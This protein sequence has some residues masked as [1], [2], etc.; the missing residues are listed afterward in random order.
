MNYSVFSVFGLNIPV[1]GLLEYAGVAIAILIAF[2]LLKKRGIPVWD[3]VGAAGYTL[4][5]SIIGA[6]LLFLAVSLKDIIE[7]GIPFIA[8]L[9]GG[10]VF[11][12]GMI[13][14]TLGMAIYARQFKMPFFDFADITIAVLPLAHAFGRVGC[15]FGGCCY[16]KEYDGPLAVTYHSSA[17]MNTPLETSLFP[18][19]LVSAAGLLCLF[20]VLLTVFLRRPSERGLVTSLYLI[21][22]P[23]GRFVIEF[24]RGDA[25]RGVYFSLSTAQWVSIVVLCVGV[26][27]FVRTVRKQK[28]KKE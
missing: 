4:I 18:L 26:A 6:K 2:L 16:G 21:L 13:G 24:F 14:G 12:G 17:N 28:K 23:I 15:F 25:E 19:Q 7:S 1:Y 10:F 5:G 27:L 20:A 9:R 11:Y 8:V 3:F 22:Y